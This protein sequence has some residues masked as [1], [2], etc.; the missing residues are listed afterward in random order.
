VVDVLNTLDED[1]RNLGI[2][3]ST[4]RGSM[5]HTIFERVQKKIYTDVVAQVLS[6]CNDVLNI[7]EGDRDAIVANVAKMAGVAATSFQ[8][9]GADG[10]VAAASV[11]EASSVMSSRDVDVVVDLS[12]PPK[13]NSSGGSGN[14]PS[15]IPHRQMQRIQSDPKNAPP[16]SPMVA[17]K[18]KPK[19]S[20]NSNSDST[21]DT[22]TMNLG[23]AFGRPH[24]HSYIEPP[25][26]G[27]VVFT[28]PLV[29]E[30][31]TTADMEAT[32]SDGDGSGAE[33]EAT[34]N[35]VLTN[36]AVCVQRHLRGWRANKN[37]EREMDLMEEY[38]RQ[39]E[40]ELYIPTVPKEEMAGTVKAAVC[41]QRYLRGWRANKELELELDMLELELENEEA[42]VEHAAATTIQRL[43]V[44][45][46]SDSGSR[47]RRPI[48]SK[49]VVNA[50]QTSNT[51]VDVGSL[52][53][54]PTT[55]EGQDQSQ[56]QGQDQDEGPADTRHGL[57]SGSSSWIPVDSDSET[58]SEG[59]AFE[60]NFDEECQF[61][62]ETEE[63]RAEAERVE[64]D[65]LD[66]DMLV[67][68]STMLENGI[69]YIAVRDKMRY[70]DIDDVQ[71]RKWT[72]L[73]FDTLKVVKQ[74]E[75]DDMMADII[76]GSGDAIDGEEFPADDG[77]GF[78]E[79]EGGGEDEGHL[80]AVGHNRLLSTI[81]EG[82]EEDD[83]EEDSEG[84]PE[85]N[86]DPEEV[87]E[88]VELPPVVEEKKP[89]PGLESITVLDAATFSTYCELYATTCDLEAVRGQM[90]EDQVAGE[91]IEKC[92]KSLRSTL[93][94]LGAASSAS[95]S[96]GG[97]AG[98]SE[99]DLMPVSRADRTASASA[100]NNMFNA[101]ANG[102]AVVAEGSGSGVDSDVAQDPKFQKYLRMGKMGMPSGA[103]RHKMEVDG[104]AEK[105][106]E[107]CMP[108]LTGDTT[109][110]PTA[111]KSSAAVVA[112]AGEYRMPQAMTKYKNMFK[113]GMSDEVVVHKMNSDGIDGKE[114]V[115]FMESIGKKSSKAL[116]GLREDDAPKPGAGDTGEAVNRGP[117]MKK[118]HFE[119]VSETSGTIWEKASSPLARSGKSVK[120]V[121]GDLTSSFEIKDAK[122]AKA[123]SLATRGRSSSNLGRVKPR[124]G[125]LPGN[126]EMATAEDGT[127]VVKDE[128]KLIQDLRKAV[129]D[130][131]WH[132]DEI[133]EPASMRNTGI[134]LAKFGN[135]TPIQEIID[136]ILN[137]DGEKLSAQHAIEVLKSFSLNHES[138]AANM[139]K[140]RD[141]V[142]TVVSTLNQA[143]NPAEGDRFILSEEIISKLTRPDQFFARLREV[144]RLSHRIMSMDLQHSFHDEIVSIREDMETILMA[145]T[146][147][148]ESTNLQDWLALILDL[149]NELNASGG[150]A[151]SNGS[152]G[153]RI[154]EVAKLVETKTNQGITLLEYILTTLKNDPELDAT[155]CESLL[156]IFDD[157]PSAPLAAARGTQSFTL[158]WSKLQKA[159]SQ[160]AL[161]VKTASNDGDDIFVKSVT[162]FLS[163]ARGQLAVLQMQMDTIQE[164]Y[165]ELCSYVGENPKT[166]MA[167]KLFGMLMAFLERLKSTNQRVSDKIARQERA[168]KNADAPMKKKG[169]G[170]SSY[171]AH[172]NKEENS[173]GGFSDF[174][175]E[176]KER[177]RK[178][179][180]KKMDQMHKSKKYRA[181]GRELSCGPQSQAHTLDTPSKR[182]VSLLTTAMAAEDVRAKLAHHHNSSPRS[183]MQKKRSSV[184]IV[185]RLSSMLDDDDDDDKDWGPDASAL[186]E[187][188]QFGNPIIKVGYLIF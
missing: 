25:R 150:N 137:M 95:S 142:Q 84:E 90:V 173:G 100:L 164:N 85:T 183:R 77:G 46:R 82:G 170:Q 151:S 129:L 18:S 174:K 172:K 181:L 99:E 3:Y 156:Y 120:K 188:D 127:P 98:G 73:M 76:V 86:S 4:G 180:L 15:S 167:D 51:N 52:G 107:A 165:I 184:A 103:V 106:I 135:K 2:D 168:K 66:P 114:I 143:C 14:G 139:L 115:L 20:S 50:F 94:D 6:E 31:E 110:P 166:M 13:L 47:T 7:P 35:L 116:D 124:K 27:S 69:P 105:D 32:N 45:A 48:T 55:D 126:E 74:Q 171:A 83:M 54:I 130:G 177:N 59:S 141:Y 64:F 56:E 60:F 58:A 44:H 38:I 89:V 24:S 131:T 146:E 57:G 97:G 111:A 123:S 37:L 187:T 101:R 140:V 22:P 158:P 133:L 153:F 175:S 68:F 149:G 75:M 23:P 49:M 122:K 40:A 162:P 78:E 113:V 160:L 161:Q 67:K 11:E 17:G 19:I 125:S 119:S 109:A 5:W 134:M 138:N 63:D 21:D 178:G 108:L 147:V 144:P 1:L 179:H 182:G 93:G 8:P 29:S 79:D 16:V 154:S 28:G 132:P 155:Y 148:K 36:A 88:V 30:A 91:A 53:R 87:A 186:T 65:D 169:E 92:L 80:P 71:A 96:V 41:V 43:F 34:V 102:P 39:E 163:V 159:V 117:R 81:G 112:K 72:R 62:S 10:H 128:A 33:M 152:T 176:I 145:C 70:E 185:K 121:F 12:S 61:D 9:P 118:L 26:S 136:S 42:D 157:F 104:L